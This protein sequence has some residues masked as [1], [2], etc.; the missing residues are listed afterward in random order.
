MLNAGPDGAPRYFPT[1]AADK[2]AGTVLAGAIGM[3]LFHRA[4]TGQ[5]QSVHVPMLETMLAF[6]LPEHMWSA[7]LGDPAGGV[8]Y[9]RMLTPH[10]RPYQT[11][12]GYLCVIAVSD[13]NWRRMFA[14]IG[15]PELAG[16]PRFTGGAARSHNIDALYGVLTEA[17]L[18]RPSA[19]WMALLD[20]ADLPN[21]PANSLDD[22]F[23]DAYLAE[24]GFFQHVDGGVEGTLTMP[25][26]APAFSACPPTI[27]RPP[28]RLGEHTDEV[29]REI[30]VLPA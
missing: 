26:I 8:G 22:L 28:P 6:L 17:M 21:G 1:V 4:R 9:P 24:T 30:G 2:L 23:K 14:V 10:R 7:T 27:R 15:R 3:A 18:A 13:E 16:D 5:G 12:D 25:S 11:A 19:E 20:A 29:M